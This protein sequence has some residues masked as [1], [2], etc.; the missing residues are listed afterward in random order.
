MWNHRFIEEFGL[1]RT[2]KGHVVQ[3]PCNEQ[4]HLQSNQVAQSP[5]QS[6]LALC[7]TPRF[8][9][10]SAVSFPA[11]SHKKEISIISLRNIVLRES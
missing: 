8:S 2:F 3:C 5:V 10:S 1:K 6:G 9:K 11:I 7:A 4:G